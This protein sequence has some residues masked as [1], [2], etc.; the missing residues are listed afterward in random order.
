MPITPTFMLESL[1]S[2]TGSLFDIKKYS[3]EVEKESL[4]P[5]DP[6][7]FLKIFCY[8]YTGN[9]VFRELNK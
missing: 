9:Q 6:V 4:D 5:E 1:I 8:F 7:D 2:K 3:K